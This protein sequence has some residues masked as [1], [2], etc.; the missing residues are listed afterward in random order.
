MVTCTDCGF[1][2]DRAWK[3]FVHASFGA[4]WLEVGICRQCWNAF[5]REDSYVK[6]REE[7]TLSYREA[8]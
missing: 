2:P 6:A 4:I 7:Q 3:T 5:M 8:F 1:A